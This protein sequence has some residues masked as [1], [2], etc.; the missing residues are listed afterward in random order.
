MRESPKK[1]RASAKAVLD[2]AEVGLEAASGS[3]STHFQREIL[4]Q[5]M[6]ALWL[7]HWKTAEQKQRAGK[8][9]YESLQKIAPRSELEG[10]LAAQM[11]STH[12][13]AM[14]CLRRAMKEEQTFEGRDQSLK[15]AVKLLGLYERQ[16]GALDKHRGK[17]QQ[18]I[19]VE[20]VTVEAGGQ[21]IVGN[22]ATPAPSTARSRKVAP[23]ALTDGRA[24]AALDA[25]RLDAALKKGVRTRSG[26]RRGDA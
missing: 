15:H 17:G 5:V 19:T 22:V 14:E 13:A 7:P 18:K 25:S 6:A 16:L 4:D 8:A 23:P 3:T 1:K 9:A 21:A 24:N 12:N 11:V 10:M 20:H 26:N 2:V